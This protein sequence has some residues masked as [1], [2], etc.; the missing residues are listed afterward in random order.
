[1][2][3]STSSVVAG[4]VTGEALCYHVLDL[5]HAQWPHMD[6]KVKDYCSD[7]KDNG[8][9]SLHHYPQVM[10]VASRSGVADF[11]GDFDSEQGPTDCPV[12]SGYRWAGRL[13]AETLFGDFPFEEIMDNSRGYTNAI[14]FLVYLFVSVFILLSMFLAILGE[15]QAAVR[16]DQDDEKEAAKRANE[17][18]MSKRYQEYL[19]AQMIKEAED[20][21][22]VDALRLQLENRIWDE[23]DKDEANKTAARAFLM[24]QVDAGRKAQIEDK[25]VR[26]AEEQLE[27]H[28][29]VAEYNAANAAVNQLEDEKAEQ[30]RKMRLANQSGVVTQKV[31]KGKTDAREKQLEFLASKALVKHEKD[32]VD[33]LDEQAGEVRLY[34]PLKHTNWYT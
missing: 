17:K 10:L 9:R 29:E 16:S 15:A 7:P 28:R 5:V 30:L 13:E 20:N 18:L 31:Y 3:A 32:H 14:L 27:G 23:K 24:G 11:H 4:G 26:E 22:T 6:F 2:T 21:T 19:A 8:Y 34:R 1:M 25:G 12:P 33:T